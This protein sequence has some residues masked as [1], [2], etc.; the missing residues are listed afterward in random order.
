MTDART[1]VIAGA[2]LA[3]GTAA[4]ALRERG[5]DARLV[6]I[7]DETLPPYE[8]PGLSKGYLR[9]EETVD[10]LF[11]RDGEWWAT[12]DV[13][14]QLGERI[15]RLDP[16]ANLVTLE[17]GAS[18]GYDAALVATGVQ[19]RRLDVPGAGL[20]GI[21]SLRTVAD[22]DAIR[23]AAAQVSHVVL[24]GFG[25]LGCEVA[26]SLRASG[27]EVEVV[28]IF[29]T[30]LARILGEQIGRTI[31]AMHRDHGV[32]MH[33]DDVV[34]RFEG[35]GGVERV[36]TKQGRAI[37]T[38]M[39]VV[40]IGTVAAADLL[41][42]GGSATAGG[43]A[44]DATLATWLPG[45]WAAGDIALHDHPLF[46]PIRIEHYDNAI[47]MGEH[48]AGS[49]LGDAAPFD[50]PHWFWSDQY[51]ERLEMAGVFL[52]E[53]AVVRGSMDDRSY[54]AFF[55]DDES[56]LRAA[57]SMGWPRDVRRSLKLIR[58]RVVCDPERLADPEFDL[59]G[60]L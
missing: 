52:T 2:S 18:I 53:H 1:F 48:V 15:A 51:D 7:G 38:S 45:V 46:G 21:Y 32:T 5:F 55:L 47:K 11:V 35:N 19:N 10:D 42:A 31:E 36:V 22:A 56:R 50:D 33:F 58:S 60:F 37:D 39:V 25:F 59:R 40:A 9:G 17:S 44:V 16:D 43:V 30:A 29:S 6:V 14:L 28:E 57:V 34:E 4:A 23:R 26:A 54:C 49:M 3:G 13:E 8:R 24:V 12:H 27:V 41:P 20:G